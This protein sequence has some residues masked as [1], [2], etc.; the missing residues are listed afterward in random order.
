MAKAND[1]EIRKVGHITPT[2][3]P[4]VIPPNDKELTDIDTA[5]KRSIADQE[6]SIIYKD[7]VR[8]SIGK[9]LLSSFC[10]FGVSF[11]FIRYLEKTRK[12]I[13]PLKASIRGLFVLSVGVLAGGI[14]FESVV[15]KYINV[16]TSY[17]GK[18]GERMRNFKAIYEAQQSSK[19][20]TS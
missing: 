11:G 13:E 3:A 7:F 9:V 6:D 16:L 10:G 15:R 17:P 4:D 5:L 12:P 2:F 20:N 1:A 14:A 8:E 19:Q 18:T